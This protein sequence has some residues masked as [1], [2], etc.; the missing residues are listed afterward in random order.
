LLICVLAEGDEWLAVIIGREEFFMG[1]DLNVGERRMRLQAIFKVRNA[2]AT[3]EK[4][5]SMC[6]KI[7][8]ACKNR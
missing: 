3:A 2:T 5:R 8:R 7:R 6:W 1:H 4:W